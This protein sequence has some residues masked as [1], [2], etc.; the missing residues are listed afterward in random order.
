MTQQTPNCEALAGRASLCFAFPDS[1]V[2]RSLTVFRHWR[3]L[4]GTSAVLSPLLCFPSAK[5]QEEQRRLFNVFELMW[6]VSSYHHERAEILCP[7]TGLT[8]WWRSLWSAQVSYRKLLL[9]CGLGGTPGTAPFEQRQS[10]HQPC[11]LPGGRSYTTIPP[12][13]L[14]CSTS[15]GWRG[16]STGSREQPRKGNEA[17]VL[18]GSLKQGRLSSPAAHAASVGLF[19]A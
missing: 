1:G 3:F 6:F 8:A 13:S 4:Q 14:G 11:P 17:P 18:S 7:V 15:P 2:R 9:E 10:V 5:R 16:T 12:I 19:T